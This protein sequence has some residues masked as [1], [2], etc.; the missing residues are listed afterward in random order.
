MQAFASGQ[1]VIRDGAQLLS[2]RERPL[3]LIVEPLS[4]SSKEGANDKAKVELCVVAFHELENA[5]LAGTPAPD[6]SPD[7]AQARVQALEDELRGTRTQ[8][9]A[10]V[11]LHESASEDLKSANEE[12]QSVNEELQSANEELETSAEEMQSINEELQ[13]V[14]NELHDKN[15]ALN[16]VNNDFRNLLD[17]TH[18]ATLFLD[19]ELR[20]RSY[21]PTVTELF[22]LRDSD[23]GRPIT[24][25]SS[26]VDY[27]Q[28]KDDVASVLKQMTVTERILRDGD[29][30]ATFLLRMRP[31][32]TIKNVVD[33]VVLTFVDIT[34]SQRLN[35]EHARLAAIVNASR[36]GIIGLSLNDRITSWNPAAE[37]IFAI[38]AAQAVGQALSQLLPPDPSAEAHDFFC[39]GG[40]RQLE[41]EFEMTWLQPTGKSVPLSMNYAPVLSDDDTRGLIAGELI[42]RDITENR[43]AER[44]AQM[45]M[46]ELNHRVKNT[47]ATVQAIVMQSA[48]A[49]TDLPTFKEDFL[50]RLM[51]LSETHNLLAHDAWDGALLRDIVERE[52]NPWRRD[53]NET[54]TPRVGIHGGEVTLRSSEALALTMALH[55]LTTNAAKYGALSNAQGRVTITW[56]T[57]EVHHRRRLTLQWLE[58]DGPAVIPP[59][60]R[61]FGSRLIEDG[62][63]YGLAGESRLE[64]PPGGVICTIDIPLGEAS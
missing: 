17:S 25:I 59:K 62:V 22:H 60:H 30:A 31:Y 36:D 2:A 49:A 15:E 50:S 14:N 56:S 18:I 58:H 19:R 37:R 8:L 34:D 42:A 61:G 9:H 40:Q 33:G 43:H 20:I 44:H 57:R 16:E 41:R 63:A 39:S 3:R 26:R 53:D 32:V 12:Y 24:E 64:F 29:D 23:K 7:S 35:R 5:S 27:P 28:L 13:I 46:G 6:G 11:D 54:D 45:M 55:E 52:L 1:R 48:T 51:A 21:T 10:A 38:P 47:L 4:S